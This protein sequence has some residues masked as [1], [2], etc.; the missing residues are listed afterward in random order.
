MRTHF[1]PVLVSIVSLFPSISNAQNGAN[2]FTGTWFIDL[3]TPSE[4]RAMVECGSATFQLTQIGTKVVGNHSMATPRCSRLN[5]GGD[6]T[7]K[8]VV[9][10]KTAVLAVTSARNGQIVL[11]SAMVKSNALHW[12]VSE[13]IQQGS[14]DDDSGLIL[15]NGVLQKQSP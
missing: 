1:L 11:G 2:P 9:I 10:G 4:K 6:G 8:G 13:E 3:R 5:E 7:V 14:P 15:R 12:S